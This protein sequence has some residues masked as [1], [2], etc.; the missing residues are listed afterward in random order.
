MRASSGG[1]IGNDICALCFTR[2]I[3]S[4]ACVALLTAGGVHVALAHQ[5]DT[6]RYAVQ[7]PIRYLTLASWQQ[8]GW[9]GLPVRRIDLFGDYE[10]PFTVQWVGSLAD[11]EA[12]LHA[13]SWTQPMPWT[14]R[15]A[16]A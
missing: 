11:L 4:V 10:E 5:A 1:R 13:G 8:G 15:S 6:Q 2:S 3:W 9:A 16:L 14:R 7:R 12:Q